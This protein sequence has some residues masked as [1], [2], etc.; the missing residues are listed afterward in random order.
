[1][2]RTLD[3]GAQLP[4][5]ASK[6]D[7]SLPIYSNEVLIS[8]RRLNID[9]ASFVQME[10]EFGGDPKVIGDQVL[11]N[12][13]EYG[14]Q[15]NPVTGSG[16]MLLG[17]VSQVGS[18]YRGNFAAKV[19]QRVA[20]LVSLTSTPLHLDRVL[21]VY[22]ETHQMDVEGHAI[23]F[24]SGIAAEIPEDLPEI[25]SLAVL[26]VAGAPAWCHALA[27]PGHT[28]V[29]FGAGGKAGLLCSVAAREQVGKSGKVIGI[30]PNSAAAAQLKSLEVCDA[31]LELDASDSLG[32]LSRLEAVTH[33]KMGDVV[34]N[35]VSAP[36]TEISSILAARSDAKVVFF[37]MATAFP[38]A[39]L[40]A[41][42]VGSS[43]Q[44]I[45]GNGY[46]PGH[47]DYALDLLR[48]HSKLKKL[49]CE[50]YQA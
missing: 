9:A 2:H 47:A 22:P 44:M 6:L 15:Q 19:G 33:G 31:V 17:R 5:G 21:R 36:N 49:F 11:K 24:E 1:M 29:V 35:V 39:A 23:L 45:I 30:E 7:N 28:V 10:K 34:I 26:D 38:K 4:Q 41:E 3:G 37:G 13:R 20:T 8:V 12:C 27:K 40:G 32:V 18:A 43:V 14:K 42:S 46:Y 48:Q 50:R 25:V 16:G